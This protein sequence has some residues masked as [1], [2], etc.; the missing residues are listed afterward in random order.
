MIRMLIA[1]VAANAAAPCLFVL[2]LLVNLA[3]DDTDS[4]GSLGALLD[5]SFA[6][7]FL[8]FDAVFST[9]F[10]ASLLFALT[11]R[12]FRW[13]SSWIYLAGGAVIDLS[14]GRSGHRARFHL[15]ALGL[16]SPCSAPPNLLLDHSDQLRLRLAILAGS[17]RVLD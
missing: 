16:H 13:R 8:S 12:Y 5:V 9:A 14:G 4:P 7:L 10:P 1:V 11:G 2:A 17:S 6:A 3:A 15:L